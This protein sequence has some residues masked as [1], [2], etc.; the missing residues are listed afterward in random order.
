MN[1]KPRG[2]PFNRIT[3]PPPGRPKGAK[4]KFTNLKEAFVEA[5]KDVGGRDYVKNFASKKKN[6]RAFLQLIAKMLPQDV[7][8]SGEIDT[9]I[10]EKYKGMSNEELLQK[11]NAIISKHTK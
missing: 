9:N 7:Q 6:S 8:I 5:F 3:N 10:V 11:I 2:T 4:S 1:K